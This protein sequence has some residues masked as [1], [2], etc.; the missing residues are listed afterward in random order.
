MRALTRF[1]TTPIAEPR[2]NDRGR[3]EVCTRRC[4]RRRQIDGKKVNICAGCEEG[5]R[6][7]Q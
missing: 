6:M 4:K 2:R 5:R 1:Q 3:C 7:K